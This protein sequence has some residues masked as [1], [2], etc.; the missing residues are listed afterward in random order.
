MDPNACLKDMVLAYGKGNLREATE[1]MCD[2]KG[3]LSSGGFPPEWDLGSLELYAL[4]VD[5]HDL[6]AKDD[7]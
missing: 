5:R 6:F 3:W 1:R 4:L 7:E 2:L